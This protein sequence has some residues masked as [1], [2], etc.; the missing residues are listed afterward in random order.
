MFYINNAFLHLEL[1]KSEQISISRRKHIKN[2]CC[3]ICRQAVPSFSCPPTQKRELSCPYLEATCDASC[4]S[5]ATPSDCQA[6]R[7]TDGDDQSGCGIFAVVAN[8]RCQDSVG[9]DRA[10]P[11]RGTEAIQPADYRQPQGASPPPGSRATCDGARGHPKKG[12]REGQSVGVGVE[13]SRRVIRVPPVPFLLRV[14]PAA[15]GE[16]K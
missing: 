3:P 16:W 15:S 9:I 10:C 7:S 8:R 14:F 11:R 13:L 6:K 1:P 4:H 12:P 5:W 2:T